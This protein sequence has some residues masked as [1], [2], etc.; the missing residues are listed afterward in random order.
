LRKIITGGI[1][2]VLGVSMA[3]AGGAFAGGNGA[4]RAGLGP[5]TG[6][7]GANS[8]ECIPG[9][10]ATNGFAIFNAPGRPGATFK[11]N[12][13]VSLKRGAPLTEYNVYLVSEEDGNCD[14][15]AGMIVTNN[16]GNG[17][18]HLAQ[19]DQGAGSYYVVLKIGTEEQF[20]TNVVTIS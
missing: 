14:V 8:D 3:V 5:N 18:A 11:F 10:T 4:A 19:P 7:G 16:V 2:V 12:G 6:S 9:G 13:E 15:P 20:A 1:A 17:N